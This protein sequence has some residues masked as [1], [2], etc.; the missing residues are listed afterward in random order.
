MSMITVRTAQAGLVARIREALKEH[1][2]PGQADKILTEAITADA[3]AAGAA[4]AQLAPDKPSLAHFATVLARWQ[5]DD[6]L[7]L[8]GV[9]LTESSLSFSVTRCAY[10]SAYA[11]MGLD[12][13]LGYTLSCSRDEPFAQ[14]YSPRLSM[15]RSDTIMLGAPACLFT[16]VWNEHPSKQ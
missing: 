14:G 15:R 8:E 16:F 4:F 13:E 2:G 10:A 7:V 5:E 3:R 6:A 12:P 1:V 9:T 11:N